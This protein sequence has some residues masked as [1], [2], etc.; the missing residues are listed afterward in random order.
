MYPHP[1]VGWSLAV[2]SVRGH[3]RDAEMMGAGSVIYSQVGMW[4]SGMSSELA[5]NHWCTSSLTV[6]LG[7]SCGEI[8]FLGLANITGPLLVWP[9]LPRRS[10]YP[11]IFG[12][13]DKSCPE[14]QMSIPYSC[15][16]GLF[17]RGRSTPQCRSNIWVSLGN[18]AR[19]HF[20]DPSAPQ[21][22]CTPCPQS[23]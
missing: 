20:N 13:F 12:Q 17:P 11:G 14:S 16:P 22:G 10:S 6:G 1:G 5:W 4:G 7:F 21:T 9:P 23:R 8:A 3:A 18:K 15:P 2:L 19:V